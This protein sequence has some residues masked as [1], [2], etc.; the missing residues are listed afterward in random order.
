MMPQQILCLPAAGGLNCGLA[1]QLGKDIVL[2][3]AGEKAH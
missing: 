2:E 1:E 3:R